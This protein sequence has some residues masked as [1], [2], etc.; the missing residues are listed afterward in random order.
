MSEN[1]V[2]CAR[3]RICYLDSFGVYGLF[4]IF[5]LILIT[6]QSVVHSSFG[7]FWCFIKLFMSFFLFIGV[8]KVKVFYIDIGI[9]SGF[10][11]YLE[12]NVVT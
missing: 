7:I 11:I 10:N 2:F 3:I 9:T 8:R 12:D 4:M 6:N 1:Y 5:R